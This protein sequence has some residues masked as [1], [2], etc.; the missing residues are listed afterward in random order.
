MV[1]DIDQ[2]C[3]LNPEGV[4]RASPWAEYSCLSRRYD[5]TD[6]ITC[7]G[8]LIECSLEL[9]FISYLEGYIIGIDSLENTRC[10]HGDDD[11]SENIE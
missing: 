4:N 10:L 2:S 1:C 9:A 8:E 5:E 6:G 3:A 11:V 7:L